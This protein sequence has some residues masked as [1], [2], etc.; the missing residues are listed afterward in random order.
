MHKGKFG[1]GWILAA[2]ALV[3]LTAGL[4]A[5]AAQDKEVPLIT[6]E[7]VKPGLCS[8]NLTVI[9][10]RAGETWTESDRKIKCAVRE[11]PGAVES[12]AQKYPQYWDLVLYC[13]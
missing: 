1:S 3:F 13:A 10:V 2:A 5:A 4:G 6:K 12:W 11:D 7:E 9:D 8:S